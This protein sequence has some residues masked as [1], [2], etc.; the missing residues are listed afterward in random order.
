[1]EVRGDSIGAAL[2]D[3][4]FGELF[5][6]GEAPKRWNHVFATMQSAS[7]DILERLGPKHFEYVVVDEC[8]H[9]P[10]DSYRRLI[11]KLEPKILLGLT[12]TPE[13]SDG[14]SL[15]PD[16]D[17]HVAA[18]LRIWHALERQLLVPFEYY[19]ISDATDLR[20]VRWTRSGYDLGELG[21][22]YTGNDARVD[23]ILRQLRRCVTDVTKIRALAFC[24]SVEH[25]E[26]MARALT[27]RG[28]PA[29]ALHGESNDVERADAPRRLRERDINVICT[30][31]L[32]NEGVDLP[33][34][35]T[36]LFLRPTQSVTLFIQQLG[37]GLR[38]WRECAAQA[39]ADE[40][41]TY[42]VLDFIGQ[43]RADFRFDATLSALTGIPRARLVK[44]TEQGF[45]LLPSGCTLRLDAVARTQVL[46]SLKAHLTRRNR[47]VEEVKELTAEAGGKLSLNAYLEATGR[48]LSEVYSGDSGWTA[49]RR[50]AGLLPGE[51]EDEDDLSR[52]LGWLLHVDEPHRLMSWTRALKEPKLAVSDV[53]N[54]HRLVMLGFQLHHRGV[55][56]S[57]REV[58]QTITKH[59]A[60]RDE[61]TELT[62]VLDA[63]ISLADDVYPVPE[64][65]LALHRHYSRREIAAAVGY[66]HPGKKGGVPQGGILKLDGQREILL[67][68]LDKSDRSF[69]PTTRYRDYAIS[70]TL[71]H[72]ETQSVASVHR[73]SGKRYVES[74]GNGWKFFLFVRTDPEA[75]Y[76]FCGGVEYQAHEGDRPIAITWR[77][78]NALPA[79][80]YSGFATLM[81]G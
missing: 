1:V 42:L 75:A 17:G 41:A 56:R 32:Y 47:I 73:A 18:E 26:Y 72:W 15:L 80:L 27:A 20:R 70:P 44:A 35:D 54:A 23:L 63:N 9:A 10:A 77:L 5:L 40:K 39:K 6:G 53:G 46:E 7:R 29:I 38:H 61:L 34:V 60:I 64:W 33:F 78:E 2:H 59:A 76:A 4:A 62:E 25:A 65:P 58:V 50:A 66:V 12:A 67:V 21:S 49:L 51:N 79:G 36:L 24:A 68:T 16:F 3:G 45:P 14:N 31:D 55:V 52:R 71:F 37:R 19:G 13:R 22:L 69:S 57:A 43:H 28:L 11:P 74:P 48:E 8:H 81:Q 30:C